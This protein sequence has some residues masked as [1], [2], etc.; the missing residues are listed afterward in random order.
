MIQGWDVH[1]Y[2]RV[3]DE[4]GRL[5]IK[6]E[7]S[8]NML[9]K[10]TLHTSQPVCLAT[11]LDDDAWLWHARLGHVNFRVMNSMIEKGLVQGVPR[12]KHPTQV[13]DRCLVGKQA[14][15]PLPKE[16]L[17]WVSRPLE[18]IHADLYG[19]IA[20]QTLVNNRYFMLIIDD[21]SQYMSI[22]RLKT[23]DEAFQAFK[24]IKT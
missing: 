7:W 15:Q 14:R 18:L 11:S 8:K 12:I 20:P 21:F 24:K 3:L 9:Y 23:K 6:V 22:Q 10:I 16:R 2:L 1:E 13:C 17:W 5:I 19:Q 4:S